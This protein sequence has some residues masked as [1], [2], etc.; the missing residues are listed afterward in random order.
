[1]PDKRIVRPEVRAEI[2]DHNKLLVARI[3]DFSTVQ[4][5]VRCYTSDTELRSKAYF[6]SKQYMETY[7]LP[8]YD[9]LIMACDEMKGAN[10]KLRGFLDLLY[11]DDISVDQT[12]ITKREKIAEAQHCE[13]EIARLRNNRNT[14]LDPITALQNAFQDLQIIALQQKADSARKLAKKCQ[15][16]LDSVSDFENKTAGLHNRARELFDL[17][18]RAE[19]SIR[20][21]PFNSQTFVYNFKRSPGFVSML[22]TINERACKEALD[23]LC[24]DGVYDWEKIESWLRKSD[25]TAAQITALSTVYLG[26][27]SLADVE[28]F[29]NMGYNWA[30]DPN[31]TDGAFLWA[32]TDAMKAVTN[33]VV[34]S[35]TALA[36]STVWSDSPCFEYDKSEIIRNIERMQILQITAAKAGAI[37]FEVDNPDTIVAMSKHPAYP[38]VV[39]LEWNMYSNLSMRVATHMVSGGP[40]GALFAMGGQVDV[41]GK[42]GGIETVS[43]SELM[44]SEYQK[45]LWKYV[46]GWDTGSAIFNKSYGAMKGYMRSQVIKGMM[47]GAAKGTVTAATTVVGVAIGVFDSFLEYMKRLED[48]AKMG[49]DAAN[50]FGLSLLDATVSFTDVNG[51]IVIHGIQYETTKGI[52][53]TNGFL[54]TNQYD[55]TEDAFRR[56]ICNGENGSRP[57]WEP[58]PP[59]E[60]GGLDEEKQL[61]LYDKYRRYYN[62]SADQKRYEK[63]LND[64]LN[65]PDVKA[66]LEEKFGGKYP[67]L[68]DSDVDNLP[69]EVLRE[70]L[71]Y[72]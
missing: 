16:A 36:L 50:A 32:Q 17:M 67:G 31:G 4:K 1:M 55:L 38:S 49:K 20:T 40:E 14:Q 21:M 59:E 34:E 2:D 5:A 15:D 8:L 65:K 43:G 63:K 61:E 19:S 53:N 41:G 42:I 71:K 28:K 27:K 3:D 6:H 37:K 45:L 51:V 12:W 57:R 25:P 22:E 26:L 60:C 29:M 68:A 44:N 72:A 70:L 58:V 54:Q 64:L 56:V 30:P 62:N 35:V 47:E 18:Q 23:E 66:V 48:G 13:E 7:Y 39:K 11:D 10:L 33:T 9:G 69:V 24:K 52:L 46:G